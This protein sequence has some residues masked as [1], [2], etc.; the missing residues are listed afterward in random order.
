MV[1]EG[2]W[3]CKKEVLGWQ[4]DKEAGTVALPEL[5][6]LE[7]L[8][9]L[10]I[11]SLQRRMG[12]K[13]LERLVGKL[14]S[15]RLAVPRAVAHIYS[16]LTK[17]GKYRAWLLADLHREISDWSAL[18]AQTVA[19]STHLAQIARREP[20]HL[21]LYEASGIGARGVWLNLSGSGTS[22]VWQHPWSP[23]IIK[24]LIL[25]RNP[26]GTLTKF[27]LELATLVV[28]EATPLNT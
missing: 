3:T 10:P 12:R 9:M 16:A 8:Q 5:K 22:H 15:I 7:L 25:D 4:I 19:R 6:H 13:E 2:N 26:E 11:P 20:T 27:D 1:G 23:N 21:G 17:G 18:V 14:C 24:A 28:H